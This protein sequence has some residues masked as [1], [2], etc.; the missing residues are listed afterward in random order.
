MRDQ[1]PHAVQATLYFLSVRANE[2]IPLFALTE[3]PFEAR[4]RDLSERLA[5]CEDE[6]LSLKLAQ[7][8]QSVLHEQIERLREKVAG[9]P[10]LDKGRKD[11]PA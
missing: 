6:G 1:T 9:I 4:V 8:L 2:I 5:E 7:E 11:G 3:M 10:L